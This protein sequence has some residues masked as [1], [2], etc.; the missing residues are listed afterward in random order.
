MVRNES[1]ESRL[2]VFHCHNS[3]RGR[4]ASDGL[5]F[6]AV[7]AGFPAGTVFGRGIYADSLALAF[8]AF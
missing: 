2:A 1:E 3:I 8:G 6:P 4:F 5:D 7:S